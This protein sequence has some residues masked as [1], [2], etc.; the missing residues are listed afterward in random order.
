MADWNIFTQLNIRPCD[1]I[2]QLQEVVQPNADS[3][4]EELAKQLM[5]LLLQSRSQIERGF[6]DVV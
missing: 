2:E 4:K 6:S 3:H 5:T 1:T